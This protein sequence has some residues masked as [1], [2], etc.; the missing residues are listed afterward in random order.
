M[1]NAPVLKRAALGTHVVLIFL[2]LA[3]AATGAWPFGL[4]LAAAAAATLPLLAALPGL[5][6]GSRYTCQW[7]AVVL[8]LYSGAAAVEV[9]AAEG[10]AHLPVLV[11][12]AALVH[13][14]LVVV[15][16]RAHRPTTHRG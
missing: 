14:G 10:R 1:D 9:V 13:L 5:G 11:L 2:V 8:V 4:R 15:L 6:R 7:L 12:L 16:S 3:W